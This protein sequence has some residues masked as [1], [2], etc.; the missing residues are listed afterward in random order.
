MFGARRALLGG[1]VVAAMLSAFYAWPSKSILQRSILGAAIAC[2]TLIAIYL[3]YS[4]YGEEKTF[5]GGIV[6][7]GLLTV[8]EIWLEDREAS[9]SSGIVDILQPMSD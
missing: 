8:V 5:I 9:A 6:A 1:V 7:L 4:M 2:L 3:S